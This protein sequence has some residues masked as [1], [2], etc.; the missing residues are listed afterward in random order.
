MS[1]AWLKSLIDQN[2]RAGFSRA[3]EN[4][5]LRSFAAGNVGTDGN[6]L[7]AAI[8]AGW[9]EAIAPLITAGADINARDARAETVLHLAAGA[10]MAAGTKTLI[11]AGAD[12]H[13][14]AGV[15]DSAQ[16]PAGWGDTP[17][18]RAVDSGNA[19]CLRALLDAGA[20]PKAK[21]PPQK[22]GMNA[23][24]RAAQSD[25]PDMIGIL[26]Q[27]PD[28]ARM[29][30]TCDIGKTHADT[31]RLALQAGHA[32]TVQRLIDHGVNING[33]DSEGHT[34]LHWL[35][36][37]RKTRAEALPMIRLL[38][39]HGADGDKAANL[40]GETP[41]M[42]S[43][44]ADFPEAMRLLLDKGAD[45]TRRSNYH[46]TA[47]HFAAHHYTVDTINILLDA[48]ADVNA[49]DR[50]GQT[51]LHIAAHHNRRDVVR[52]LLANDADPLV[53]DKRGRTPD[54]ICQAPNQEFTRAMV[55]KAQ[56]EWR[57]GAR[58]VLENGRLRRKFGRAGR[59][60]AQNNLRRPYIKKP[61][62]NDGGYQP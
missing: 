12:I 9:E 38:L 60:G 59:R 39:R 42:I 57:K 48:G 61:P 62:S 6:L 14:R 47:L 28:H 17:L 49:L 40:W 51:P 35:L 30:D 10:G 43:A 29:N 5:M 55:L 18:H 3:L 41:L 52:T 32:P 53:R 22:G 13:A 46:E 19:D 7:H 15:P 56:D 4:P 27:H 37:H 34:P 54:M 50:I 20:D 33:R 8:R 45:V 24:H 26:L 11:A 16:P 31:F 58:P 23:W 25:N 1:T 44:K 2:D 36:M 21:T